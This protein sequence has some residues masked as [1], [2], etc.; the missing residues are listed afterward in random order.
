MNQPVTMYSQYKGGPYKGYLTA[1]RSVDGQ[2]NSNFKDN[3]CSH[4]SNA[5]NVE[6]EWLAVDLG[7]E[8]RI[9]RVTLVNRG[10]GYGEFTST[11]DGR[12]LK[13]R[14]FETKLNI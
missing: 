14:N 12:T 7:E 5:G 4:S 13:Y 2:T 6:N 10:D 8:M 1:P 3:S 9:R 11:D